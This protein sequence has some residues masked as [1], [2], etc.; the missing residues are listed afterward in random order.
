M[1]SALINIFR[2]HHQL[3]VSMDKDRAKIIA[4]SR[5]M[6]RIKACDLDLIEMSDQ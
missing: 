4:S 5:P 3:R 2:I 1:Y 6:R